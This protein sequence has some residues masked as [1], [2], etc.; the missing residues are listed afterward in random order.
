[1]NLSNS[2]KLCELVCPSLE[3]HRGGGQAGGLWGQP[4]WIQRLVLPFTSRVALGK[5]LNHSVHPFPPLGNGNI[6]YIF[7]WGC[8]TD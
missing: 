2:L 8:H 4:A 6:N 5:L 1:M 3:R 7:L